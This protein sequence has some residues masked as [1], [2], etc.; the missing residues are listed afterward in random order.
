MSGPLLLLALSLAV[1]PGAPAV[2][3]GPPAVPLRVAFPDGVAGTKRVRSESAGPL[4][5]HRLEQTVELRV[6]RAGEEWRVSL[7]L[8]GAEGP[9]AAPPLTLVAGADGAFRRF[10]G[11]EAFEAAG[12]AAR[13]RDLGLV[14]L[15]PG[16]RESQ[17]KALEALV[18]AERAAWEEDVTR[19]AGKALV[20]GA[21]FEELR[22]ALDARSLPVV[23][24]YGLRRWLPCPGEEAEARCVEL[25]WT[26]ETDEAARRRACAGPDSIANAS[27]EATRSEWVLV[28][29]PATLLP[30]RTTASSTTENACEHGHLLGQLTSTTERQYTWRPR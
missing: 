4:L 9:A 13:R 27:L 6:R 11:V 23:V 12:L 7:G 30:R 16:V 18:Q 19:W 8:A 3:A 14:G 26:E 21:Y 24:R 1:P 28:S 15:V 29:D 20:P 2:P 22:P 25:R 5:A 17:E 10:E